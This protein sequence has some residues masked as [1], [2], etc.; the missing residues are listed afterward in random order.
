MVVRIE[1][2][3]LI[4]WEVQREF[5]IS[6]CRPEIKMFRLKNY[7]TG[8]SLFGRSDAAEKLDEAN[9]GLIS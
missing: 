5:L 1:E 2:R 3:A 8:L 7:L 6:S 9:A 4:K